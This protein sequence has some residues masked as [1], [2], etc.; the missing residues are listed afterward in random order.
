V[1][2]VP[3]GTTKAL[4][5]G[6]VDI[7]IANQVPAGFLGEQMIRLRLTPVAHPSHP[8]DQRGRLLT[9]EDLRAHRHVVI[10]ETASRRNKN[11]RSPEATQRWTV[12]QSATWL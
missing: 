12:S 2:S 10:H 8:L 5:R 7:A 4:R 3:T 11:A 6:A 1:E 9:I